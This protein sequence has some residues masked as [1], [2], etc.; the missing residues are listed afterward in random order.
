MILSIFLF[1]YLHFF[2]DLEKKS[3]MHKICKICIFPKMSKNNFCCHFRWFCAFF[4]FLLTI[5]PLHC[6][7]GLLVCI[8]YAP[9][10]K[11]PSS[12]TGQR[13]CPVRGLGKRLPSS[14]T[15]Q[16]NCPVRELGN[17]LPSSGTGQHLSLRVAQFG[18]WA[19]Q[20]PLPTR[21]YRLNNFISSTYSMVLWCGAVVSWWLPISWN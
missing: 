9:I 10:A 20:S 17:Q 18:N 5:F 8:C 21:N 11:L 19:A 7:G 15:G 1:F 4:I 2:R 12:R 16:Q 6:S 3:M 14:W 13:C